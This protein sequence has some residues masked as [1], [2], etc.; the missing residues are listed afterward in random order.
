MASRVIEFRSLQHGAKV[1]RRSIAC[2]L[3]NSPIVRRNFTSNQSVSRRQSRPHFRDFSHDL[4]V[5]QST[6]TP[7]LRVSGAPR[8]G[9]RCRGRTFLTHSLN[10]ETC[11]GSTYAATLQE[12]KSMAPFP[13]PGSN[14]VDFGSSNPSRL[15]SPRRL[16]TSS[17]DPSSNRGG[18]SVEGIDDADP[19]A[20][21]V[22]EEIEGTQEEPRHSHIEMPSITDVS[23]HSAQLRL[24]ALVVRLSLSCFPLPP[25]RLG[26]CTPQ[27]AD[28]SRRVQGRDSHFR[29][30]DT[31]VRRVFGYATM[32]LWRCSV[33][34]VNYSR[35][36]VILPSALP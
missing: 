8:A 31:D 13:P 27:V 36:S 18:S 12:R 9:R 2:C 20:E 26:Y 35:I 32:D 25:I 4:N 19:F 28:R 1:M 16:S 14:S 6:A 24:W 3:N 21:A 23:D 30:P 29:R 34:L 15:R 11:R 22:T 7:L 33:A 5:A 10:G 17:G